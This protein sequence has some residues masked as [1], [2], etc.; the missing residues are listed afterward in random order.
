M[1]RK[2]KVKNACANYKDGMCLIRDTECPLVS[3]FTY[4]GYEVPEEEIQCDYYNTYVDPKQKE[5]SI[6]FSHK[7]CRT[8]GQEF[9]P[10]SSASKFC[11]NGCRKLSRK[12]THRKYNERR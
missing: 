3:G 1:N 6:L 7:G 11:S 9:K 12:K 4:R 8:C 2:Q 10:R 5:D